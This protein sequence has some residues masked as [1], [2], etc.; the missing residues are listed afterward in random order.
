MKVIPTSDDLEFRLKDLR[1][2]EP[3]VKCEKALYIGS[4]P[5]IEAVRL[6][7]D[8]ADSENYV[9]SDLLFPGE[10]KVQFA[11]SS[12]TM[13]NQDG[14][15]LI[16][17]VGLVVID[18][19]VPGFQEAYNKMAN[20]TVVYMHVTKKGLTTSDLFKQRIKAGRLEHPYA[21]KK[22]G[23]ATERDFE[24]ARTV[25]E[26]LEDPLHGLVYVGN[27]EKVK[28]LVL[29]LQQGMSAETS[30]EVQRAFVKCYVTNLITG[31][32]DK[33]WVVQESKADAM[34]FFTSAD[35]VAPT[36]TLRIN[37]DEEKAIMGTR[38]LVGRVLELRPELKD[39]EFGVIAKRFAKTYSDL[40]CKGY[41]GEM[42]KIIWGC[43]DKL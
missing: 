31:A 7:L 30:D 12:V 6:V 1:V 14:W 26:I 18:Q 15:E 23:N 36:E 19:A 22:L 13:T 35:Y 27:D 25:Y 3:L 42:R 2:G 37:V 5:S 11:D 20:G 43:L 17:N 29:E 16:N 8:L 32:S 28:E 38:E 4:G 33:Y 34:E 9:L 10:K 41:Q 40:S 21:F 24:I 39:N